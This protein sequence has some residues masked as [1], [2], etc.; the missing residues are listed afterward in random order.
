MVTINENRIDITNTD[1]VGTQPSKEMTQRVRLEDAGQETPRPVNPQRN[2]N[3]KRWYMTKKEKITLF[4]LAGVVTVLLVAVI[5][6]V[7]GMLA[8]PADDGRILKG[9]IAAGVNLGGMTTDEA[10]AALEEATAD[11]YTKLDMVVKVLDAQ[12]SLSPAD[13]GARLDIEAVVK[14]A[15]NYG[16]TGSRAEQKQA[17][18][19]ALQNSVIIPITP[20]LNLDTDFI[21][22]EL[23][24]LGA[25]FS[26]TLTDSWVKVDGKKPQMD[27]TKPDTTKVHQTMTIYLGTAEYGLDTNKLFNQVLEYYNIN[28]FQVKGECTVHAPES[29]EEDLL[30]YYEDLCVEPVDAQIDPITYDVTPEVYGYGFN[31]SAVKEQIAKSPY[32]TTL[33]IPLT[34]L[35]PNLT[36]ELIAGN[37][38]KD[39]IGD[40]STELTEDSAW[41]SN[42]TL[43][44]EKLNGLIIKSGDIFS[45]NALLGE[46]TAENGYL[47]ALA[48]HKR[49]NALIWGGGVSHAASA[50]YNSV[51]EAELE[52]LERHNHIYAPS[53][54]D[55]GRDAYVDEVADFRFRNNRPDPIRIKAEIADGFLLVSIEGTENRDY[56]VEL[57]IKT[58]KT[59]R[60]G[61]LYN[62]MLEN[63]PGGYKNGDELVP[64]MNGYV[65]EVYRSM[66]DK[67]TGLLNNDVFVTTYSYEAR[68]KVVVS[69]QPSSEPPAS[70]EGASEPA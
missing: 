50:L 14:D 34:Y 35:T 32:G 62:V 18:N 15:Y 37:L 39:V 42:A 69:L 56:V 51:L 36:E 54:I 47:E 13:T 23:S 5:I 21:R 20:H 60:P 63:N 70:S 40:Y 45:F 17:K 12:I 6:M 24:K 57:R 52:I 11:T 28:I 30:A 31:L 67:Q 58:T 2:R 9:V 22:S 59:I 43:A 64:G 46:L 3:K 65:I 48:Y 10:A 4:S 33:E 41:N 16:R 68:D 8:P 55:V 19:N 49:V 38:F 29:V 25:Q 7:S 26:S 44:C 66:Y 61:K 1:S 27:V 53:F